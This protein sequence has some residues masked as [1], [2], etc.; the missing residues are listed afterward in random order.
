MNDILLA[1]LGILGGITLL[2]L[3]LKPRPLESA[4]PQPPPPLPEPPYQK[5]LEVYQQEQRQRR[6]VA[7]Q[8]VGELTKELQRQEL[9]VQ[10]EPATEAVVDSLLELGKEVRDEADSG[11]DSSQ[12]RT[13]H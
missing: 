3:W 10:R 6:E 2:T 4:T 9:E 11:S 7:E 13:L 12:T 1:V 8:Y 5:V